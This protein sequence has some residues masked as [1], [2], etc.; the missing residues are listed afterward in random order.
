MVGCLVPG[1]EPVADTRFGDES[2]RVRIV[3]QLLSKLVCVRPQIFGTPRRLRTP[4]VLEDVAVGQ[5]L[6]L[7]AGQKSEKIELFGS[8]L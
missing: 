1:H 8:Q 6:A 7:V 4:D 2:G 5:D 3:L